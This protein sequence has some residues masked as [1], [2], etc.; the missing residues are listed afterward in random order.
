MQEIINKIPSKRF[1]EIFFFGIISGMPFSILYTTLVTY[2]LNSGLTL[3]VVTTIGIARIAYGFKY[4]WAPFVDRIKLPLLS[5]IGRRKSWMLLAIIT[6][7]LALICFSKLNPNDDF[8]L[9]YF[10]AI[11]L[12][13]SSATYDI[14][15]DAFRI[16]T[17]PGEKQALG[18]AYAVAG[19]RV[20]M[21]IS[22]AGSLYFSSFLSWSNCFLILAAIFALGAIYIP[23][24]NED[25]FVESSNSSFLEKVKETIINPFTE[26]FS[27]KNA[28]LILIAVV[29]YKAGDVLLGFVSTPFYLELGYTKPQIASV[30]KVFG[31]IA[32]LAGTFLGGKI[33]EK[34]GHLRGLI[35]CGLMQSF[36]N[37]VF[38]W[39]HY[40]PVSN[41]ALMLTIAV[42]N[43][44]AGAGTAAEVGYLSYLCNRSYSATQYALLSSF[45][46]MLNSTI[47][48]K[49]GLLVEKLGWDYFFAS[50]VILAF[51]ALVIFFFI[52]KRSE[53]SN[54][55]L[56][57]K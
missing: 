19:Y 31:L 8:N 10:I 43:I 28:I 37:L 55:K 57:I 15:F 48:S 44:G 47:S 52:H 40:A 56:H 32:T 24:L 34:Y 20:G 39:L 49:A 38:I 12:G 1:L 7:I 11:M 4:I 36:T 33:V 35:I 5:K 53:A 42:E 30:A 54:T 23:F 13:F 22:S 6:N 3:S 27:R 17:T 50:T 29:L 51:P 46:V 14:A 25:K 2:L 18:V 45:A 41:S 16:D 26:F 9:I 21:L